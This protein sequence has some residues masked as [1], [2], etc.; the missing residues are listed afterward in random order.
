MRGL[1]PTMFIHGASSLSL[2]LMRLPIG[3]SP[4]QYFLAKLSFTIAASEP[5]APSGSLK[6]RPCMT[7]KPSPAKYPGTMAKILVRQRKALAA[8]RGIGR[9]D[10]ND[11]LWVVEGQPLQK[12]SIGQCKNGTV[13]ADPQCNCEYRNKCDC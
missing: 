9:D 2:S 11:R 1:T 4:G 10:V 5:R 3:F 6:S 13:Y 7:F 8:V 12:D